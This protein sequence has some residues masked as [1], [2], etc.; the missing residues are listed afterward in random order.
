MNSKFVLFKSTNNGQ[1]YWN[2]HATNGEKI[3]HS[4]GYVSRQG[5]RNGITSVKQNAVNGNYTIFVGNDKQH[6]WNLKAPNHEIIARS[7][8]YTTRQSAQN[9]I[10]SVRRNAPTATIDDR[11]VAFS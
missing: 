5:A 4:E 3:A 8:G 9:G 10:D 6:Y 1:Y 2:L 7:E 11:T